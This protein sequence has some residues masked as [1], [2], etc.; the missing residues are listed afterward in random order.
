[1]D[2]FVQ[3]SAVIKEIF[4]LTLSDRFFQILDSTKKIPSD[5]VVLTSTDGEKMK[6]LFNDYWIYDKVL[7]A[8]NNM[9]KSHLEYLKGFMAFLQRAYE[10]ES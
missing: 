8:Y 4:D 2:A 7:G 9:L 10:I 3:T 5:M 6:L 1:V